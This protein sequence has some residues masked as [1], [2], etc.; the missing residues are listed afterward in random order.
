MSTIA[1]PAPDL[2]GL[3][4]F[5]RVAELGSLD[6]SKAAVSKQMSLLEKRLG[7]QLLHR[8]VISSTYS[9]ITTPGV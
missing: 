6:L 5:V 3:I 2:A 1:K 9:R 4:A 7:A 8:T